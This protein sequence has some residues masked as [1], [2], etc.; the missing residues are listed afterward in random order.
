[1]DADNDALQE[2]YRQIQHEEEKS[3]RRAEELEAA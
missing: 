1:M 3:K 2:R